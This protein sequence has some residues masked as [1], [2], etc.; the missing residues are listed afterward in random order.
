MWT[1]RQ[2]ER[3][4]RWL[5]LIAVA[6]ALFGCIDF[7]YQ[8]PAPAG[9][10]AQFIWLNSGVYRRAQ[11]LFYDAS[12]LGNFCAFFLVMSVVALVHRDRG[13]KI[14]PTAVASAGVVLFLMTLLLSFS[15]APL[16]AAGI[17]CLALAVLE[18]DRWA[19]SRWTSPR[20]LLALAALALVA[21][22]AFAMALPEFAQ[23]YWARAGMDW[24]SI[25]TSPDRVLSGR[26]E[27]WQ[28]IGGFIQ[29]HPWQTAS[30][31]RL[32]DA[33]LFAALRKAGHCR[34]HV[35]LHRWWKRASSDCVRYWP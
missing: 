13:R 5:F 18:K 4:A 6:A 1:G 24:N 14:L 10:G 20:V 34:Q 21:V 12:A 30:R 3:S 31:H 27:S 22:T 23:G 9:F 8:L 2:A 32:Q 15:R 19:R 25:F 35:S 17:G 7:V 33:A 28:T 26:L 11:G 29:E 16:L